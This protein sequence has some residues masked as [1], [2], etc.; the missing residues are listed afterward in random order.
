MGSQPAPLPVDFAHLS[1]EE[2]IQVHCANPANNE[3]ILELWYRHGQ[4]RR[5]GKETSQMI[6]RFLRM[7]IFRSNSICPR[8]WPQDT[9]LNSSLS[10]AWRRFVNNIAGAN[11]DT[12]AFV[13]WKWTITKSAAVEEYWDVKRRSKIKYVQ[14]EDAEDEEEGGKR[15]LDVESL[16]QQKIP[17]VPYF[18]A[19]AE[20]PPADE[21]SPDAILPDAESGNNPAEH[22][23]GEDTTMEFD[24]GSRFRSRRRS[25]LGSGVMAGPLPHPEAALMSEERKKI[26]RKLL[27]LHQDEESNRTIVQRYFREVPVPMIALIKFGT[28]FNTAQKTARERSVY[29]ELEHDLSSI[30]QLLGTHF[31]I[32]SLAEI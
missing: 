6:S 28:P 5:D 23:S 1:D 15:G 10:R 29:H 4:P 13:A 8:N 19:P 14:F 16:D 17:R 31:G 9:F 7:I 24:P 22:S 27:L 20:S 26:V 18:D 21:H 3:A 12:G 30:Q 2:L 32:K 25:R 11:L